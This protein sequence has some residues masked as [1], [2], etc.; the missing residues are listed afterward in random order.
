MYSADIS[1]LFAKV[2]I[3]H[4]TETFAL[5]GYVTVSY[6]VTDISMLSGNVP[7]SHKC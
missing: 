5:F 1:A 2:T 6:N 3:S 4:V 7:I